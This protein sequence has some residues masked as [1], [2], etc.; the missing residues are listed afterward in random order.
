V[1]DDPVVDLN[2]ALVVFLYVDDLARSADFYGQTL[3]LPLVLDQGLCRLYQVSAG[4]RGGGFLGVC[5]SGDRPTT[6]DGVIVTLVRDD[7]DDY[8]D[9]LVA[10]GVRLEQPPRYN[11]RFGIHHAFLRDPDGH[12]VEVQRFDDTGWHRPIDG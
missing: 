3:G 5:Q 11:E 1:D 12:L 6:P 8:C 9:G 4:P 7:V 2:D 10:K